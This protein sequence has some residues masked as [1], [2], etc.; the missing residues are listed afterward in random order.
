MD[1]LIKAILAASACRFAGEVAAPGLTAL[2]RLQ[3]RALP[4]PAQDLRGQDQ[5]E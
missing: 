1:E 4:S 3:P 5:S 2:S